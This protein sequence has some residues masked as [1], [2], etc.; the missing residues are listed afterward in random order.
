MAIFREFAPAKINLT[1]EVLGK[2]PD[3][4]HE[5]KSLVAFASDVGDVVTLDTSAR[6]S[7]TVSGSFAT[8]IAGANLIEMTLKLI[9]QAAPDLQLGAVH[10]EKN[11]PV[12][13]GIGGGSADAAAVIRAVIA[14]NPEAA[15]VIDWKSIAL[16]I[17]AD[18]PVCLHSKL[19]WMRGIGESVAPLEFPQPVRLDAVVVN[20]L[21]A[22]PA[23]KTA[24][25]FRALRAGPLPADAPAGG[26]DLCSTDA[27]VLGAVRAGH[28]SLEAPCR[29]VVPAVEPVLQALDA[30]PGAHLTRMSGG[31]PTCFALFSARSA[32]EAAAA[33]LAASQPNWWIRAAALS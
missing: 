33:A 13:A 8:S 30:L 2:R 20:P 17:G 22:V 23:D 6:V 16:K 24:Q 27:S 15:S 28:N 14:A 10:L 25:V 9:A 1:L 4:Y 31:G 12:A 7:V 3:G 19:A 32:A 26:V 29:Q 11:L 21:A 5:L 18:V